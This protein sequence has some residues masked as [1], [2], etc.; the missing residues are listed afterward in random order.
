LT[1]SAKNGKKNKT[2]YVDRLSWKGLFSP[3]FLQSGVNENNLTLSLPEC[4]IEFCEMALTFESVDEI[5]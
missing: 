2:T 4:L 3:S 5:L 1:A